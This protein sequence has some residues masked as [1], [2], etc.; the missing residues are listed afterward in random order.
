MD[1]RIIVIAIM[2]ILASCASA[3]S[4]P[5]PNPTPPA[6]KANI[7]SIPNSRNDGPD[8]LPRLLYVSGKV[9]TEDG[10]PA[11]ERVL[12]QSNCQ[13]T[14]RTEGYTN[15]KGGFS[16][17]LADPRNRVLAGSGMASDTILDASAMG[18]LR[19]NTPNDWRKCELEAI[20]SG[21]I[22]VV[23]DLATKP[24]AFG[25]VNIGTLVLRRLNSG[26]APTISTNTSQAPPKAKKAYEKGLEAKSKNDLDGAE[27]GFRK[28][29]DVYPQ[30]A[31]AWLELGRV[32]I[33]KKDTQAAR[34]AFHESVRADATLVS[35]YQ[36]LAQ[37][38]AREKQWQEVAD[39]T[40]QLLKL[41]ST[42][43][44]EFWFYNCIAKYELGDLD[45]AERS[46]LEGV[47]NDPA[48]RVPKMEYVLGTILLNK[49][50]YAGAAQH[51]RE[52]L[53]LLPKGPDSSDA[54]KKVDEIAKMQ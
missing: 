42:A 46:A 53:H 31:L 9:V 8:T 37:L 16:I 13:G 45:A 33:Q 44:P 41:N 51:L 1:L 27:A 20:S 7:P 21:F 28:A 3:Q 19:Q 2:L 32:Q 10:T 17:E 52:Y 29:L 22:S 43:Y 15:H 25:N 4:K 12:I 26:D 49:H 30:F 35:S 24:P 18:D 54:Q 36:E 40:D 34:A 23:V 14:V 11:V 50:E 38:A 47:K 48:R 6:P 39:T 5:K